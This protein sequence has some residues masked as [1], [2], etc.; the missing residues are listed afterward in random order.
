M[1]P[2]GTPLGE[3]SSI[4]YRSHVFLRPSPLCQ[5][6]QELAPTFT[7]FLRVGG[8]SLRTLTPNTKMVHKLE[9]LGV[10]K[11]PRKM[12]AKYIHV[13]PKRFIPIA[14]SNESFLD[15]SNMSIE[16]IIGQLRVCR[17]V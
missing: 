11:E 7:L 6:F 14:V 9:I 16:E 17:L 4:Y 13:V 3:E 5:F 15:T 1:T 8:R 12:A 2:L 10:P